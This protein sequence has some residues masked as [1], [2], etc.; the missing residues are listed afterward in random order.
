M[1]ITSIGGIHITVIDVRPGEI[2]APH[3]DPGRGDPG[4]PDPVGSPE[5]KGRDDTDIDHGGNNDAVKSKPGES[6]GS[7]AASTWPTAYALER[8]PSRYGPSKDDPNV[9]VDYEHPGDNRFII[10]N[11]QAYPVKTENGQTSIYDP[12]HP[13]RPAYPVS[14]DAA[15]GSWS[16][17]DDAGQA[18]AGGML[19]VPNTY[20]S[21]PDGQLRP[22]SQSRGVYRDGKGQAFIRQEGKTYAVAY[23]KDN[24]TWRVRSPEGGTKPS[25]PVRLNSNGKWELKPDAGLPGGGRPSKY[26]DDLGQQLYTDYQNGLTQQALAT[27]YD[28][29]P[30]TVRT[31]VAKYARAHGLPV[32]AGTPIKYTKYT[33]ELGLAIHTDYNNGLLYRDIAKKHNIGLNTVGPWIRKYAQDHGLP[34]RVRERSTYTDAL[35]IQTYMDYQI[36]GLSYADLEK[37]YGINKDTA[38]SWVTRYA[39]DNGLPATEITRSDSAVALAR[40][41]Y[42]YTDLA[43]GRTLQETANMYTDGDVTVA[44][45]AAM[46]HATKNDRSKDVVVQAWGNDMEAK[47]SAGAGQGP[48]AVAPAGPALQPEIDPM[49]E[50]QY[51][52]ILELYDQG[53]LTPQQIA[54][55]TGVPEA[56]VRNVEHGYGY[57]SPSKQA[58]VEPISDLEREQPPAKRQRPDSSAPSLEPQPGPSGVDQGAAARVVPGWGRA[59]IRQYLNEDPEIAQNMNPDTRDAI[60]DWLEGNTPAPEGLQQEMIDQGY[61]DLT[62]DMVRAYFERGSNLTS[63]QRRMVENWLGV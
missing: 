62:P 1:A 57:F 2:G 53:G 51:G 63:A 44:Y 20:V 18:P 36:N 61:L 46:R 32:G 17:H 33:E 24:E 50:Q 7:G 6:G 54:Q 55:Q 45:R 30:N 49:S 28:L 52:Q 34:V 9:M 39:R 60:T 22:D 42:I 11:D 41:Q 29:N 19:N 48:A 56:S 16:V 59:E 23:D 21:K 4:T 8:L 37:K 40:G 31:Y 26:T 47:L 12:Q 25:Y 5:Q 35:G 10:R 43:N 14:Y 15:T 3:D 38:K 27:K 13:E 58:Y